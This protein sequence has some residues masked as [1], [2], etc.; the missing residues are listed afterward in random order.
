[1]NFFKYFY[2]VAFFAIKDAY[3]SARQ[4][5]FRG[6]KEIGNAESINFRSNDANMIVSDEDLGSGKVC[7]TKLP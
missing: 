4:S 5:I 7:D 1:M 6:I 3:G 2:I